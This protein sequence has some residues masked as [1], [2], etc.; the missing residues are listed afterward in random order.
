MESEHFFILLS[1]GYL[2][3]FAASPVIF[4]N[5]L[6]NE[7]YGPESGRE[8]H[9]QLLYK[10][11]DY[12]DL[13]LEYPSYIKFPVEYRQIGGKRMRDMLDMRYN[14]SHFQTPYLGS[15]IF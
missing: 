4:E 15:F 12:N 11:Y 2:T 9:H 3:T 6:D 8:V 5:A 7:L 10:E 14:G 13:S 1:E